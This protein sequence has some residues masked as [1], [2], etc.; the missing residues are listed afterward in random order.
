[1]GRNQSFT[2][3]KKEAKKLKDEIVRLQWIPRIVPG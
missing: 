1:M 3:R 2:Q